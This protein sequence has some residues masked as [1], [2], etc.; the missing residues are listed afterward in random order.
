MPSY[1]GEQSIWL[2]STRFSRADLQSFLLRSASR[3]GCSN[4]RLTANGN[5]CRGERRTLT[6]LGK[7]GSL[8]LARARMNGIERLDSYKDSHNMASSAKPGL[9]LFSPF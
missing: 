3:E 9:G 7:I 5:I 6:T 2:H 1:R 8:R 4:R